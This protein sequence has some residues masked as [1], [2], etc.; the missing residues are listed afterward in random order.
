MSFERPRHGIY[1]ELPY[2]YR[3][4][5]G[6]I[7]TTPTRVLSVKDGPGRALKYQV[8]KTGP[9]IHIR[10]GDPKRFVEGHQTYVIAYEVENAILFF[11]DHDEIYWNVTGNYWKA[12]IKEAFADV[13]LAIKNKSKNLMAAGFTGSYGSK[14]SECSYET[15]DNGAKFMAKRSFKPGEGLTIAF[16][17]DKGLVFPP[18]SWKKFLWA[19]N[20]GETGYFYFPLFLS[21]ICSIYGIEG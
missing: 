17:W 18:S 21:S 12:P 8:E 14:E 1:R 9:M 4:E 20:I 11:N 2:K 19:I 3:D 15:Y 7:I 6:K 13:C 5:F 10:I 16:G